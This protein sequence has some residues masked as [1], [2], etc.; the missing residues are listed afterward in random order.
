[1]PPKRSAKASRSV[2]RRK[3]ERPRRALKDALHAYRVAADLDADVVVADLFSLLTPA[4]QRA[5]SQMG[6]PDDGPADKQCA[7]VARNIAVAADGGTE[8]AHMAK[9]VLAKAGTSVFRS[10]R[11]A[12]TAL[13]I[14]FGRRLWMG[15]QR[16]KCG[17]AK[18]GRPSKT[19]NPAVQAKVRAY[20]LENSQETS[21][22]K[23]IQGALVRC[24]CLSRSN[25]KLWRLSGD[26]QTLMSLSL[27][28]EHLKKKHPEFI[29]FKKKVDMCPICHKYDKLVVPKVRKAISEALLQITKVAPDYFAT[30]EKMWAEWEAA[31]QTDPDG[32]CS[33]QYVRTAVEHIDAT[34]AARRRTP[35]SNQPSARSFRLELKE[36][37]AK[38]SN[39]LKGE[40]QT[41]E[42]CEHHFHSWRR[43]HRERERLET[44]LPA[45]AV[46]V[47]LDYAEN[48]TIPVGPVEEQ[49]WFWATARLSVSVLGFYVRFWED[50]KLRSLYLNYVSQ[51]LD[52][53]AL[54]AALALKDVVAKLPSAEAADLHVWS[55]CGPHFR[56]YAFV[57]TA[58]DLLENSSWSSVTFHF[59]GEHHGKGRNDG[60]FGLQKKW[61]DSYAS[62][63][64]IGTVPELL[65]AL[66]EGAESTMTLDP[67]PAGPEYK[68]VHFHPDKPP[69]FRYLD[70]SGGDLKIEYTYCLSFRQTGNSNF[71]VRIKDCVYSDR[72]SGPLQGGKELG[73]AVST[74][75]PCQDSDWRVSYRRDTPESDPLPFDLLARRLSAQRRAK[76]GTT[77][78]R[79]PLLEQLRAEEE[80]RARKSIKARRER[81]GLTAAAAS[82]EESSSDSSSSET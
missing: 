4:E 62:R 79:S 9:R 41:L 18:G 54:H 10:K 45:T 47:Q 30:L 1:M 25:R 74:I 64:V 70:N 71:P 7:E 15:A 17:T 46:L 19:N 67:P 27:W 59:F 69:T 49:S 32:K 24:R 81:L 66:R 21:H 26:M 80:A 12:E 16:A 65:R 75:K 53:T 72:L 5:M 60:Q 38:A 57:A 23:K 29:K 82:S 56:A 6:P 13:K 40:L 68:I 63:C 48:L 78:R 14:R 33:L 58:I 55:D 77:S 31:G 8:H 34:L 36:A 61:L 52:H 11:H 39:L 37:E 73:V 44:E 50:G 42:A 2:S 3:L 43:Q 20:L 76:T 22:F 28:K 51:I 35:V